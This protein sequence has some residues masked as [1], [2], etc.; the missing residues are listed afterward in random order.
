MD[1]IKS[2][3]TGDDAIPGRDTDAANTSSSK[4][5][6]AE[7]KQAPYYVKMFIFAVLWTIV[8]FA[9]VLVGAPAIPLLYVNHSHYRAYMRQVERAMGSLVIITAY[10]F[11]PGS[12]LVLTGDFDQMRAHKKNV[13]FANH[14]VLQMIPLLGQGMQLLEFIF[15][16]QKLEKDRG[17]IAENLQTARK[18]K[19]LPLWMLI[20]PE[21]GL[22]WK[23]GVEKSRAYAAKTG[24]ENHPDHCILP[25]STGLFLTLENL[26]PN[27]TDAFD[28]TVGY[29]GVEP[30]QIPYDVLPPNKVFLEDQYPREIHVHIRKFHVPSIPGFQSTDLELPEE[31][32]RFM[33]DL[34]LQNV[35]REKDERLKEFYTYGDLRIKGDEPRQRVPLIPHSEDWMYFVSLL[36]AL[37][38]V[39]PIY[40]GAIYWGLVLAARL[41]YIAVIGLLSMFGFSR[42]SL[43]MALMTFLGMDAGKE[44]LDVLNG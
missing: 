5:A 7:P 8:P 30:D 16:N 41:G 39:L 24:I 2:L 34:W 37:D 26:Q 11:T 3:F 4:Q 31:N 36:L 6:P 13:V 22:N 40:L 29:S 12:W 21:G 32:R 9:V 44:A 42:I 25:R 43:F 33:F 28:L 35:W 19:N 38:I 18:D 14:Q 23:G 17:V 27:A 15:L 1:L 20:F 10:L